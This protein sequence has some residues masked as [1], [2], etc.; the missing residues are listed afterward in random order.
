ME[1]AR[2]KES[3]RAA[4]LCLGEALVNSASN[5]AYYAMFQAAQVALGGEGLCAPCGLTKVCTPVLIRN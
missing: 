2:A 5:R 1:I 3:L 4:D